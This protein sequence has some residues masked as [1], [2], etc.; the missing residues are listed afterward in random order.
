V[1]HDLSEETRG[2]ESRIDVR[3]IHI[4]G[5]RREKIDVVAPDDADDGGGLTRLKFVERPVP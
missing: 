3:G 5:N 1:R 2:G 4:A